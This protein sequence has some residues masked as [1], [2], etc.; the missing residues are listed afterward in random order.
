L[1]SPARGDK[2]PLTK[3]LTSQ[4]TPNRRAPLDVEC[5]S[6]TV[7]NRERIEENPSGLYKG[8]AMFVKIGFGFLWI[9]LCI[10]AENIARSNPKENVQ[11]DANGIQFDEV[12][13][14]DILRTVRATSI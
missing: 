11:S 10:H 3:A 5:G 14:G 8:D 2:S 4:R 12:I 9:P 1:I 13:F 7:S 6:A